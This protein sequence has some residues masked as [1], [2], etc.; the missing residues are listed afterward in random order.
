MT[1]LEKLKLTDASPRTPTTPLARKR[2]KLLGKLDQQIQAAQAEARDEQFV[3]EIRRW[4]NDEDTGQRK[5]VT[6]NRPVR[7]WWWQSQHGEWMISLRDGNR[8]IPLGKNQSSVEV[9]P[10]DEM[11]TTLETLRNAVAGGELD[12]QLETLIA[13]RKIPS[14]KKPKASA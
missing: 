9:G 13:S 11:V 4:V 5:P 2:T 7:K 1:I 6:F 14:G 3:E 10:L 8:I 12:A